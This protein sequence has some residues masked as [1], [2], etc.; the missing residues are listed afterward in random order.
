VTLALLH[1]ARKIKDVI[2]FNHDT[3]FDNKLNKAISYN[4][5]MRD[6]P[7]NSLLS[8]NVLPQISSS[9]KNIFTHLNKIRH[10]DAYPIPR[11]ILLLEALSKD[12]N[13]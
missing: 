1:R 12:L 9:I 3:D 13:A 11:A 6:F 7:I 5:L 4:N 2:K 10:Q 8:A